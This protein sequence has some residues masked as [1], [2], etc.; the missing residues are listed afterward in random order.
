ML[1]DVCAATP[2]GI[3]VPMQL[4]HYLIGELGYGGAVINQEDKDILI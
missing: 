4:L 1:E 2:A 3:A